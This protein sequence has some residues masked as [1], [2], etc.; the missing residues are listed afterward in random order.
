[1]KL[2]DKQRAFCQEYLVDLNGTQAAIR[3]GYSK[4]TANEQAA[5]MLAKAS[6]QDYLSQLMA[7]KEASRIA[8]ADE[9]LMYLTS[10]IRGESE[11]EVLVTKSLGKDLGSEIVHEKKKPDEKDRLK[12][13]EVMAKYHGLMAPQQVE[14]KTSVSVDE[15]VFNRMAE[16]AEKMTEKQLEAYKAQLME[17]VENG[18]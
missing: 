2:T 5:R 3:A 15:E 17:M 6:I 7:R 16:R 12:A 4:R 9:V 13:A 18:D 8:T 11:S 14:M 10:V 1:M